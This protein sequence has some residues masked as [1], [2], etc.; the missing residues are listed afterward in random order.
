M[1]ATLAYL[2]QQGVSMVMLQVDVSNTGARRLYEQFGFDWIE[3]RNCG[4][5]HHHSGNSS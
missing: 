4:E 2:R 1:N 3:Q 5:R